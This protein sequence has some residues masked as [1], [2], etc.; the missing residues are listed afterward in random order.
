MPLVSQK[1]VSS[2]K[3]TP[4][5]TSSKSTYI[6]FGVA[7]VVVIV[8][9]VV[10]ILWNR[11]SDEPRNDGYGT[12]RNPAV[13]LSVVDAGVVQV[14]RPDAGTV[15]DLYEDPL[16]PFCGELEV[17]HG[18]ELA[19][20]IDDGIVTVRY[21]LLN[22]LD[23]SSATGTYS[24]RAV[25]AS[26]CVAESENA[27]VYSAFHSGLFSANFQPAEGGDSD[28]TDDELAQLARDSGSADATASCIVDGSRSEAAAAD[29]AAAR[30]AL[31]ESGAKGTPGVII[32]GQVVDALGDSSWLEKIG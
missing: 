19:Q 25:A 32:D 22:F 21:H 2:T 18:Q 28:R 3:Y 30:T 17:G 14:G 12:V 10:A 4:Q 31:S 11:G 15:I 7:L 1:K 16:C 29:A 6:L 27:V 5:P 24:S 8:V 13:E 9:I 23:G 26:H 20:K